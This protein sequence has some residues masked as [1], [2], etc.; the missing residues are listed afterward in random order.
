MR[1]QVAMSNS[2]EKRVSRLAQNKGY[3][4]EKVGKGMHH[5]RFSIVNI[6]EGA[7]MASGVSSDPYTFSLEEAEA[8]LTQLH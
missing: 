4:I 3:R 8:W 7:R 1:K 5:G 2:Q 6:L